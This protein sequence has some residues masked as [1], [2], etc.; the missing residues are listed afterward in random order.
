M[1]LQFIEDQKIDD[2]LGSK[3]RPFPCPRGICVPTDVRAW[4]VYM[5]LAIHENGLFSVLV[6]LP[7][8]GKQNDLFPCWE[9]KDI[10]C[11][12]SKERRRISSI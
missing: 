4:R 8:S 1:N 12:E 9:Q 6:V 3:T 2:A 5:Y 10:F 11:C 7:S